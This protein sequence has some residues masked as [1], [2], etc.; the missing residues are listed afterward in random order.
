MTEKQKRIDT[1]VIISEN[2]K[3]KSWS[4]RKLFFSTKMLLHILF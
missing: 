2:L 1:I 4:H 3:K